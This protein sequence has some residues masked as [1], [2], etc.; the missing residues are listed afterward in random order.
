MRRHHLVIF[1]VCVCAQ[2]MLFAMSVLQDVAGDPNTEKHTETKGMGTERQGMAG[3]PKDTI[4][5]KKM[6]NAPA[7][8][9]VLSQGHTLSPTPISLVE[10]SLFKI[11]SLNMSD[12]GLVVTQSVLDETDDAAI[13]KGMG[14]MKKVNIIDEMM[15]TEVSPR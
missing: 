11:Q 2:K 8:P 6:A 15:E 14:G 3:N 10:F 4:A 5:A 13:Q 7:P 12:R 9:T 1:R